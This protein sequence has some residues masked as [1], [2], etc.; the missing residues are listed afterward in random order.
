[1]LYIGLDQHSKQVTVSVREESGNVVLRR[2]VSTRWPKIDAFVEEMEERVLAHGGALAIVEVCGFNHWLLVKL[3]AAGW[4]V[5]VVQPEKSAAHKTDRRDA[6][7]LSEVLWVNRE[8]VREGLPVRGLRQVQVPGTEEQADR[9]LTSLR[10]SVGRE[11]T[12]TVNRVKAVLRRHNLEQE[13]PT[14]GLETKAGRRWLAELTLPAVERIELNQQLSRLV[15]LQ[16]QLQHLRLEIEERYARNPAAQRLSTIPGA[17]AYAA[18]GLASRVG[19]VRRFRHPRSLANYWGL[20]PGSRNSGE[21]TQR[22]G[23][24]TKQ[25]SAMARFLLGQLV[26]HVLRK[27]EWMRCWFRQIKRRRGAKIARVAVMRRL[28]T[29][30]WHMLTKNEDYVVGGPPQRRL[31]SSSDSRRS[32]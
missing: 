12:R 7:K 19:D 11:R 1:M 4:Q 21:A 24:I 6:S 25:G 13:C 29:I 9:R 28:A 16:D 20:T 8:R 17:A 31:N 5:I 23:S 15:M 10:N 22:L 2:Q 3:H 32:A 27:D 18:L 30:I 26:L 14:K